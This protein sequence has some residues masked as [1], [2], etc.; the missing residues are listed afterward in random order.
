ML[1]TKTNQFILVSLSL[2]AVCVGFPMPA[3]SQTNPSELCSYGLYSENGTYIEDRSVSI[4]GLVG[5]AGNVRVG[6]NSIVVG[7]IY[8]GANVS[9]MDWA[10]VDGSVTAQGNININFAATII[11]DSLPQTS[12]PNVEIPEYSV[13]YG[14]ENINVWPDSDYTLVPGDYQDVHAY[15]RSVI[16]LESGV[17]NMRQFILEADVYA[18]VLDVSNG[19]IEINVEDTFR[20]GDRVYY[21]VV[22]TPDPNLVN[23][24]TNSDNQV[25]IGND[26]FFMGTITAPYADINVY[27]RANVEGSLYGDRVTVSPDAVVVS[28]GC[29]EVPVI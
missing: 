12:V 13:A 19:P 17:Y 14:N 3:A 18:L 9:V 20:Y 27:S 11:G 23:I 6:N 22:G 29:V 8:S 10:I 16:V 25:T 15:S 2:C 4:G 24:Y 7:D 1:K 28:S 21:S 5:S 26:A